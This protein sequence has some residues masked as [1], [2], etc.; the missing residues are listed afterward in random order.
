MKKKN[1]SVDQRCMLL[2]KSPTP[3]KCHHAGPFS[4]RTS[5][6]RMITTNEASVST[7]KT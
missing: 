5:P 6:E 1:S 4:V 3:V 7:P 2:K